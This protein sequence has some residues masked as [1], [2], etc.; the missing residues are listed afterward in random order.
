[1]KNKAISYPYMGWMGLFVVAPILIISIY[2]FSSPQGGFTTDHFRDM[3]KF[4]A[5]FGRSFLLAGIATAIS[6]VIAYP[7]AYFLSRKK[8][9]SQSVQ[10]ILIMLPMWMNMLVR[11]YSWVNI[12]STNGIIN[13]FLG[14]FGIEPLPLLGG[15]STIDIIPPIESCSY[16]NL[17]IQALGEFGVDVKWIDERTIYIKGNQRYLP[18]EVWVEGDYSNA[19]FFAR[20][21]VGNVVRSFHPLKSVSPYL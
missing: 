4:T 17:T 8:P 14:L 2:A 3:L 16:I 9:A 5:A 19:A 1:M 18:H 20:D 11:T 10:M 6:L 15:D 13:S 7:F 21:V 12:L